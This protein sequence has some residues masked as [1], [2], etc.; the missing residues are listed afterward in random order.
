MDLLF[1]L[2]NNWILKFL[3]ILLFCIFVKGYKIEW[4]GFVK[5]N[6]CRIVLK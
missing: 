1:L 4:I 6:V 5:D 2:N 3:D